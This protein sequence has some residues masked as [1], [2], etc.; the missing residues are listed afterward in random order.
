MERMF[1][2]IPWLWLPVEVPHIQDLT[3]DHRRSSYHG[4]AWVSIFKRVG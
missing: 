2:C 3:E 4:I 1:P